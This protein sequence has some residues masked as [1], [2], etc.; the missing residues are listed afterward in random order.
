MNQHE[1]GNTSHPRLA[2]A[3][4][5]MLV[6][7]TSSLEDEDTTSVIGK[8]SR[9]E[10]D[11]CTQCCILTSYYSIIANSLNRFLVSPS[12]MDKVQLVLG[13]GTTFLMHAL[14]CSC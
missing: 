10:V 11:C 1:E 13:Q 7:T 8:L 14:S 4:I 12:F 6:N 9:G 2:L 5:V 3:K